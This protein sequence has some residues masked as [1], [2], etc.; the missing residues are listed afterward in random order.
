MKVLKKISV[1]GAFAKLGKDF[2]EGDVITFASEGEMVPGE[3]GE[4]LTFKI[5]TKGSDEKKNLSLNQTSVNYLIDAYGDDTTSWIGKQ[6]KVWVVDQNVSG[7]IRAVVYLTDPTWRK[8]RENGELKF[9]PSGL[10]K[11]KVEDEDAE[12]EDDD[13]IDI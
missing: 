11:S 6:V 12:E 3:F 5:K 13:G 2:E 8:V 10:E 7:K 9:L 4:K 1:G